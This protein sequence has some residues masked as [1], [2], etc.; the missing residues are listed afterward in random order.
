MS[1]VAVVEQQPTQTQ[2]DQPEVQASPD[3]NKIMAESLWGLNPTA[4]QNPMQPTPEVQEPAPTE[5]TTAIVESVPAQPAAEPEEVLGLDDYFQREFGMNA[6]DFRSKWNEYSTPKEPAQTQQEIEW[7]NEDSKR[8][9]EYLKD[10]KEDDIYNYLNQKKQLEKLEKYDVADANQ[11][12]EI[13]RTN[14]QLK[15]KDLSSGE[16]DRLFSRQYSMPPKPSQSLDQDDTEYAAEVQAWENQV[17]EKQQDMIIDAKL[18]KP[19][20]ANFKSQIVLPD[21]QKPQVQQQGPT[22]EELQAAEAGRKAYLDAV[23]GNY[24]NFKGFTVTAKDGEVQLPISYN[25]TPEEQIAS[26]D[27]VSNINVDEFFGKRWFDENNNPKINLIQEDLYLLANREKIHQKIATEAFTQM[28][29]HLIKI[30]NNI[31]LTGVNP[32]LG[33][34]PPSQP[35]PKNESQA[36]A[37]KVWS[38]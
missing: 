32:T 37:E 12:A 6:T 31:N 33:P 2:V 8:F 20:L 3:V 5:A 24:Q 15:H 21:I 30:Q 26:K 17:K 22:Q 18:A 34:I 35:A 38:M 11:A 29:A 27:L 13:I 25:V 19:E 16:I 9:F 23:E 7:A 1:E 14:L 28:K 10:G 4:Y 36:L